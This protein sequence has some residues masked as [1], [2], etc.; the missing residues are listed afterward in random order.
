MGL[1]LTDVIPKDTAPYDFLSAREKYFSFYPMYG[2]I[3]GPVD[4]P[5]KQ[6]E[7]RD[8]RDA[9]GQSEYTIT[10]Q[11]KKERRRGCLGLGL[12]SGVAKV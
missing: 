9:L 6:R 10:N 12:S 7:I 2:V 4:F 11:G 5:H 3:K 1:E 8:Y